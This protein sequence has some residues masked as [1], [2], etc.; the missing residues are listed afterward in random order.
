MTLAQGA[1]LAAFSLVT[2]AIAAA[3]VVVVVNARRLDG[4]TRMT[5]SLLR[6][7]GR[8]P[9]SR[10]ETNRW[11]FYAHRLSGIAIFAFLAL[12]IIDVSLYSISPDLYDEVHQL[13]GTA[14]MRVFEV[15]LLAALLFH[16]FNGLRV[17]AIDVWDVGIE[18]AARLLGGVVV[19]TVVLTVA[20]GVVILRP[21]VV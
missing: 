20:G 16:A 14:P 12:H 18:P 13:Y 19:L 7:L 10:T 5:G 4:G 21:L 15:G 2:V 9:A 8:L 3:V 6:R 17:I 11:A 1:F